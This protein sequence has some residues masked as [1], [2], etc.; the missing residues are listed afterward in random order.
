MQRL[1]DDLAARPFSTM[2]ARTLGVSAR[3]LRSKELHVLT[4]GSR[5]KNEPTTLT[6]RS[7]AYLVALRAPVALSHITAALLWGLPLPAV[8]ERQSDLDV[9]CGHRSGPVRRNG[10]IGHR[11]LE[12]RRVVQHPSGVAVTGLADTW[13]D[14]GEVLDRGLALDDLVV[15]GDVAA[16]LLDRSKGAGNGVRL[17]RAVL[18]ARVRPRGKLV[19]GQA[20]A[21]VS[22][23]AKSPMETRARLMFHRGGLPTP[24]LN[25]AVE[26]KD[27]GGGGAG[28]MLEGDFV[29]R[30]HRVIGEYQGKHHSDIGQRAVDVSRRHLA[31][32]E[33]WTFVEIFAGDVYTRPKRIAMLRRLG[34]A[35]GVPESDLDLTH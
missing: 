16:R 8:L 3:E 35:L 31:E 26:F 9:M 33:G 28:W 27:A 12:R 18:D 20:L 32:D 21:L 6:E 7:L 10:C 34:R 13:V 22:P 15:A 2:Q 14:L 11:G 23:R 17:M 25:V 19:L 29:W 30:D 5:V 24:E 4:R 1:P